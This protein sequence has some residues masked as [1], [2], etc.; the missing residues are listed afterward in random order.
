MNQPVSAASPVGT[1]EVPPPQVGRTST[2]IAPVP[3]PRRVPGTLRAAWIIA[4]KDLKVEV[5]THAAFLSAAVFT[6]LAAAIF[7]YT[8]DPA[9]VP[10]L[11]LAPG[12]IWVIF[13]FSGLLGLNRSFGAELADRAIDGLLAAPIDRE[14]VYLGKALANLVFVLAV[15]LVAVPAVVLFYNLSITRAGVAA[16]AGITVLAAIGL[17]AVGTLFSAMAVNTRLAEL[18]LP[19]LALPFLVPVVTAAAQATVLIVNGR[20]IASV[21]EWEKLLVGFDLVFVTACTLAYPFTIER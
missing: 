10:A 3:I 5:R 9:A 20:P 19:V 2:Q 17:V 4:R 1:I 7:L 15:Q 21:W 18:L 12:V 11:D 6:V 13:A 8:W 14:G 16:L